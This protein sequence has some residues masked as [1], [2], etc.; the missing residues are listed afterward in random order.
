MTDLVGH[1]LGRYQVVSLLGAGG[2][3]EVYRAR[4][5][6]LERDV[7]LKVLPEAAAED[8]D[9]LERFAREAR[10]VARLS[11]PNILEIHD[12]GCDDGVHYAVAELLEGENLRERLKRGRLPVRKAVAIADAISRG[13]GAAH[14]QGVVHRDVK[15]ENVLLTSDG[16]VKVL[17][18]GI[19][20]LHEPEVLTA[21][22][23]ASEV[24]TI[25]A[26]G[27]LLGT[28][29]YMA[30]EQ[31]RGEAADA[32]SDVFALGCVLYEMLTGQRAFHRTT[33]AETL[34]AVLHDEPPPPTTL[35]PD[36]PA[37]IDRVVM[38]CLEKEPGERFQ[39]AADVA[40]ALRAAEGSRGHRPV[41][42][43]RKLDRRI[44]VAAI[45]GAAVVIAG[46]LAWR[47][48]AFGPP[49]LPEE[50]HLAV[51]QFESAHDDSE[52]RLLA[53]GLGEALAADLSLLEEQEH[54]H[55]WVLP[56]SSA[57]T[58]PAEQLEELARTKGITIGIRGSIDRS[59]DLARIQ[60]ALVDPADGSTLRRAELEGGVGNLAT[61]QKQP[62]LAVAGLLGMA[63]G[64]RAT[65]RLTSRSTTVTEA[66]LSYLE[67]LGALA[68]QPPELE[69]AIARLTQATAA[70]PLFGAAYTALAE[71]NRRLFV[72]DKDPGSLKGGL[73]AARRAIA[74]RRDPG[75][76]EVALASL[77]DVAGR[78]EEATTAL[79]DAA[80]ARSD[81]SEIFLQLGRAYQRQNRPDDAERAIQ[82]SIFLRPSY[83]V[84]HH[85]LADTYRGQGRYDAA[86]TTWSRMVELLPAYYLGYTNLGVALARLERF[87]EAVA[88]FERSL[89]LKPD[90]N[91]TA[92]ANL[93]TLYF[94][95]A[96]YSDAITMLERAVELRPEDYSKW[97]YLGHSCLWG[98]APERAA[99]AF[100]RA[101]ELAEKKLEVT[102]SD[103]HLLAR[104]AG[105]YAEVG[106][107]GDGV[108]LM[109]R[110]SALEI[111]DPAVMVLFAESWEDLEYRE[112]ALEWVA[113]AFVSGVSAGRFES[114]PGMREL[115]ADP[116]YGELVDR[117]N[118]QR[119]RTQGGEA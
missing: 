109:E 87:D 67:G 104:L 117:E 78:L 48:V 54:G 96:R 58:R 111:T 95:G 49:Q 79:E 20:S 59:A 86:A 114:R 83:G 61:L 63:I 10:A 98:G 43:R 68:V 66:L 77:L 100:E 28:I 84:G 82:R 80:R 102:P 32:R 94:E 81:S 92:L 36:I 35:T 50:K 75:A 3:G 44:V 16:R 29:G 39:S 103:P 93:G 7:A 101:I 27:S 37:G 46:G 23:D 51:L 38:R 105:Y 99:A 53:L 21:G 115:L 88:M 97:G 8:P 17:D 42:R 40:F 57:R 108:P 9:R 116:R 45:V 13:L 74:T 15:P 5:T 47:Y 62:F 25:T 52:S 2:M 18:F 73:E 55:L 113:R 4:D 76:A 64:E 11:H 107:R 119:E 70:D 106:R 14:S 30:P 22:P 41:A 56:G 34:A 118:R 60:L 69:T 72:E 90:G 6:V 65:E 112:R 31:V 89:E 1:T 26:A 85:Y 110:A 33:P 71:A 12:V 24:S 19:A 91:A